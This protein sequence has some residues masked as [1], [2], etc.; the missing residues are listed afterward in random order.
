MNYSIHFFFGKGY[1]SRC[2]LD[3]RIIVAFLKIKNLQYKEHIIS[4]SLTA[5]GKIK[6]L[7]FVWENAEPAKVAPT[8]HKCAI[9]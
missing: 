9:R 5:N 8:L 6:A 1:G 3:N 2:F 7:C 4:Y